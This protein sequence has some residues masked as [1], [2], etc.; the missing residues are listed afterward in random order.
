MKETATKQT[1]IIDTLTNLIQ[2]QNTN[3]TNTLNRQQVTINN[4][5]TELDNIK[6][7]H[8]RRLDMAMTLGD[9]HF[10]LLHKKLDKLGDAFLTQTDNVMSQAEAHVNEMM[11]DEEAF[12]MFADKMTEKV[13]EKKYRTV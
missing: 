4:L 10:K 8:D 13:F 9:D 7:A 6:K 3:F 5:Q 1:A 12:G 2:T 11:M